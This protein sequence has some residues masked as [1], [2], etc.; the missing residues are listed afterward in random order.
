MWGNKG[1]CIEFVGSVP[2]L[3]AEEDLPC[4][5]LSG[6]EEGMLKIHT[7]PSS[8]SISKSISS[9]KHCLVSS[10]PFRRGGGM[11]EGRKLLSTSSSSCCEEANSKGLKPG[12]K[13]AKK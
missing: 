6:E 3:I 13:E 11:A 7:Q 8:A 5:S 1:E 2:S 4:S 10:L 12:K 9:T